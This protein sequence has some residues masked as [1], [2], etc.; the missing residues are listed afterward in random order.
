MTMTQRLCV[1][2]GLG[3]DYTWIIPFNREFAEYDADTFL[4]ALNQCLAPIELHVGQAFRFGR[5]RLGDVSV[6]KSWGLKYGCTIFAHAFKAPDGGILS[7][8]RIRQALMDGDVAL[9]S[10]LLGEP[11]KLT[12]TVSEGDGRGRHLGF[13]TANLAWEQELLPL[14]GVYLTMLSCPPHLSDPVPGLTNIGLR[15]TFNA[16]VMSVETHLPGLGHDID[17]YGT[18]LELGFLWRIRGEERFE[19]V[20]S[21]QARIAE[22][23]K[24]GL[25]LLETSSVIH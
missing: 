11:F 14:A 20:E 5:A 7:S 12:G 10:A 18:E 17:L 25:S 4:E 19:N 15:P 1:F 13:P 9:A 6:L 22:D 2:E 3:V 16:Q 24:I 23:I 8:R 21:L